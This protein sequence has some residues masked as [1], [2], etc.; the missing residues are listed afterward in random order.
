MEY[1]WLM[2]CWT[3]AV[4]ADVRLTGQMS[5]MVSLFDMI[6]SFILTSNSLFIQ[7]KNHFSMIFWEILRISL[8][9]GLHFCWHTF[10]Q[11]KSENTDF[12]NTGNKSEVHL[13]KSEV[14]FE[15]LKNGF[16][17]MDFTFGLR[18]IF[19]F[20][21]LKTKIW[22]TCSRMRI[23]RS[24]SYLFLCVGGLLLVV[25]ALHLEMIILNLK[26]VQLM[27]VWIYNSNSTPYIS[28]IYIKWPYLT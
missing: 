1:I 2:V 20:A 15:N 16:H 28:T 17:F 19:R 10:A 9:N 8:E 23:W 11:C 24:Q 27:C 18:F 6:A 12:R 7:Q 14:H 22:E 21:C 5:D 13:N 26:T 25:H 4:C 3:F